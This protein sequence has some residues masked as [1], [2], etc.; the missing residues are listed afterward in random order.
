MCSFQRRRRLELLRFV[1][2]RF[3]ARLRFVVRLRF[4]AGARRRA[5]LRFGAAAR[6]RRRRRGG[7]AAFRFVRR[8]TTVTPLRTVTL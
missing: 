1:V 4:G 6:L 3:V 8:L 2:R 7:G 5:R